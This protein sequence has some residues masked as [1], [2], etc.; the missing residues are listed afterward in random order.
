MTLDDITE[1]K[2][3]ELEKLTDAEVLAL[4]GPLLTVT[5]PEL[6][7]KPEPHTGA[8]RLT[9]KSGNMSKQAKFNLVSKMAAN[10]G[11]DLDFD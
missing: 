5:R 7:T 3:E 1:V 6:C 4:Y 11:I 10:L 9:D 2:A 8:R